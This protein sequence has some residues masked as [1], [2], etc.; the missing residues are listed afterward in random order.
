MGKDPIA[1]VNSNL[2]VRGIAGLR[3]QLCPKVRSEILTQ[4]RFNPTNLIVIIL[5]YTESKIKKDS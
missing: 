1:V 4:Q 3:L 5:I 2:Q